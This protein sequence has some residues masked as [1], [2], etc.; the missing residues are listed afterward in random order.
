MLKREKSNGIYR[1]YHVKRLRDKTKKHANCEYFVLDLKHDKF[2]YA[3]LCAY[4]D[5]CKHEYPQLAADLRSAALTG[6]FP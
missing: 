5:A 4:S 1:K 2:A 6:R 3:A